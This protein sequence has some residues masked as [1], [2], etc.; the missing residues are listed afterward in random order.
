MGV[1]TNMIDNTSMIAIDGYLNERGR[2]MELSELV[3]FNERMYAFDDRTGII[4]EI[5]KEFEAIPRHIVMEGNG[6]N[7]KGFKVEWS[8]YK[9]DEELLYFGSIGRE[10]TNKNG[11]KIRKLD[12]LWISTLDKQGRLR[13]I[14]WTHQYI[15]IRQMTATLFPGYL[16]I[17]AI[18]WS[19]FHK[20]WFIA[21]RYVS[22]EKYD[23]ILT[24][25]RGCNL[26]IIASE[27]FSDIDLVWIGF[28]QSYK[29]K[30]VMDRMDYRN[31]LQ[32][33]SM[34]DLSAEQLRSMSVKQENMKSQLQHS[35]K[36]FS[37]IR[38]LPNTN[39]SMI[40]GVRTQERNKE[41]VNSFLSVF[42]IDGNVYLQSK[43]IPG[44]RKYEGLVVL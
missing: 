22:F 3:I 40:V 9:E 42:D 38:F 20:K 44:R 8:T 2:G 43:K 26:L 28:K 37:S 30:N 33:K 24:E 41:V 34:N 19:A 1:H 21:P 5:S 39:D 4:Y 31:L 18:E 25:N 11:T 15:A 29:V 27:D 16:W 7:T 17:E 6:D 36:G 12:L 14:D 23:S 10:Y 32:Y 13:H 35:N